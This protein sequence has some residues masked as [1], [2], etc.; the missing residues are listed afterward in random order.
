MAR[1]G[2]RPGEGVAPPPERLARTLDVSM[3]Q[4]DRLNALIEDLLDV[5]RIEAGR[6]SYNFE[7]VDVALLVRE[8]V[9]RLAD[10]LNAAKCRLTLSLAEGATVTCDRFR[11]EQ[12][13]TNL[14][15]NAAKYGAGSAVEVRASPSAAGATISVTDHGMGIAPEKQPR[16]F[17]RFERAIS[18]NNISGLGLGL[19]IT[20]QIVEAHQGTVN[21]RSVPGEGSTFTVELV[22]APAAASQ[23]LSRSML[24]L[25]GDLVE[26]IPYQAALAI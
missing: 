21:V 7:P 24:K 15:T 3:R 18:H 23:A 9:E 11:I 20:R 26:S 13:V 6:M 1:R 2:V 4:L 8:V 10:H 12:V 19:Y 16:I 17:D 5:S 22:K 14:M 25:S